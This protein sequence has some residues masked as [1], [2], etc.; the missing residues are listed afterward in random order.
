MIKSIA[1]QRGLLCSG[2]AI[3]LAFAAPSLAADSYPSK[4]IR[5]LVGASAGG[6]TDILARM[7]ADKFSQA[8]KQSVIV[9]NRPGASQTIAADNTARAPK[10]GYTLLAAT[11]TN[12]AIAP[13][14]L[15]L[16]YDP[17]KDINAVGLIAKVPHVLVVGKDSPYKS[18]KDVIEAMKANP[19]QLTYGSSGIG[20]TQHI[21]GVAFGLAVGAEATHVPYKGSSQAHIDIISGEVSMMFDTSS[22]SMAQIRSGGLR[23]LAVLSPKRSAQLPDV[24]TLAESGVSGA[25]MY[26]WY[27]M[28]VTG[29]TDPKTVEL[30]NKTLNQTL[31][32]PDVRERLLGLGGEITPISAAEMAEMNREEFERFGKLIKKANLKAN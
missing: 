8:L 1:F 24:P 32:L 3:A 21:A 6:G 27:G 16:S 5:I 13:H 4:P 29:G 9:E 10:D 20:S 17:L 14:I 11:N 22:S 19:G 23:A 2:M 12:Q 26:T 7:F 25:D 15:K 31:E 28:F 18:V 30:L